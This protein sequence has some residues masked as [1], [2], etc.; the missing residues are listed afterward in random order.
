MSVTLRLEKLRQK[1]LGY[2]SASN[3]QS[4]SEAHLY[5]MNEFLEKATF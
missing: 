3:A 5:H 4:E 1:D 2:K